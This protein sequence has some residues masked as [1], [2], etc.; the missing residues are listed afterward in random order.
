M[1]LFDFDDQVGLVKDSVVVAHEGRPRRIIIG[2]RIAG[3]T[4]GTALNDD[5][6]A[7]FDKLVGS[8]RKQRDAIFLAFDFF[9]DADCHER[10]SGLVHWWIGGPTDLPI[11]VDLRFEVTG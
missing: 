7:A 4:A 11:I 2:I 5:P 9:G 3:A 8:G 1:R 10:I 6:V